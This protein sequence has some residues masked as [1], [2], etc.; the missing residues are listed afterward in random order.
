MYASRFLIFAYKTPGLT[1]HQVRD[2]QTSAALGLPPRIRD[3]DCQVADLEAADFEE[4]KPMGPPEIF[5]TP[6]EVHI[7]YVIGMAQLARLC[8]IPWN[9]SIASANNF[10]S[11]ARNSL[12]PV[13]TWP[14]QVGQ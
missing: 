10:I 3:E 7:P 2:Q 11:S 5:R 14:I 8:T 9:I 1:L 6:P 13:S 12:Q 4:S